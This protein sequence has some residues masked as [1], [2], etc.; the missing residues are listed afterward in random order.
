MSKTRKQL[1][2]DM[3]KKNARKLDKQEIMLIICFNIAYLGLNPILAIVHLGFPEYSAGVILGGLFIFAIVPIIYRDRRKELR[4]LGYMIITCI[5]NACC[6]ALF[7][8]LSF[9]LFVIIYVGENSL[10]I[11]VLIARRRIG[12]IMMKRKYRHR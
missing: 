4:G 12:R 5:V 6:C 9:W 8:A 10:I 3:Q 1:R 11:L 7:L 2:K